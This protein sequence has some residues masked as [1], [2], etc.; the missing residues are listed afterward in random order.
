[1]NIILATAAGIIP[2]VI[3][4]LFLYWMDRYEKEPVHLLFAAFLWGFVPAAL[5]SL[6]S[7]LIFGAPFLLLDESGTL[8]MLVGSIVLAPITEEVFKGL[9]VLLVFLIW[10][11]EFD[12][13][14]DGII[15]G[16]LVGFG[17]A[18]IEN[19]LYFI[20]GDASLIVFRALLFGLNHALFTSL[21][22]IGFGIARHTQSGVGRLLAPLGGLLAAVGTHMLHNLSV[23]FVTD[24]PGL[25][26]LAFVADWSGVLFVLMVMVLAI[27][28]ERQWIRV[29]LKDEVALHTL[30]E[31]QYANVS[32][33]VRRFSSRVGALVSGGPA[34][35]IRVGRFY[36][37]L[38]EL[39]YKKHAASRRGEQGART[40]LVEQLRAKASALKEKVTS[41]V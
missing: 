11:N 39:A 19:I 38:T 30:T 40:E 7:Q 10:S 41:F 3:Y 5:L 2:M 33:P 20:D 34:A 17:F 14:F 12:G 36:H 4:P 28:R 32:H 8:G 22:G 18:A 35:Y 9:A 1:M 29:Q 31:T 6:V 27:R 13:I 24:V 25:L 15:Y 16:G 21:T 26:C 23:G 37:T